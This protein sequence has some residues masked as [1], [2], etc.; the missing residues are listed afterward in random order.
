MMSAASSAWIVGATVGVVE[1][2][3]DQGV[4]RWNDPIR[5]MH[6]HAKNHLTRSF[7]QAKELYSSPSS[8][9]RVSNTIMR[10]DKAKPAE[11]S[12]RKVMYLNSWVPN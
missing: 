7:S 1:V 6:Q 5:L 11:V 10:E 8:A 12:M 4:C 9:A 3:K 2:L